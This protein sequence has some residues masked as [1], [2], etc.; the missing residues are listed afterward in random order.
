[1]VIEFFMEWV[2]TAP[3]AKRTDAAIALA[4]ACTRKDIEAD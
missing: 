2:Q 4:R 3:V 1:M